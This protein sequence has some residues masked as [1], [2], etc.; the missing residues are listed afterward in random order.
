MASDLL[1]I[2]SETFSRAGNSLCF[3][4]SAVRD[5]SGCSVLFTRSLEHSLEMKV[6]CG[7]QSQALLYKLLSPLLNEGWGGGSVVS[8]TPPKPVFPLWVVTRLSH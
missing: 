2:V 7:P 6:Y 5:G 3:C 4:I 1:V 8:D